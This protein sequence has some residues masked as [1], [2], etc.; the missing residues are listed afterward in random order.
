M[1]AVVGMGRGGGRVGGGREEGRRDGEG[2]GGSGG[3]LVDDG[4]RGE[5]RALKG[6]TKERPNSG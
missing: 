6:N 1:A 4:D 5:G 3:G 2:L